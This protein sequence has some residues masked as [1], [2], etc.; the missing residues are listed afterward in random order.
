MRKQTAKV[1]VGSCPTCKFYAG[2]V[3]QSGHQ[4]GHIRFH[5]LLIAWLPT[6]LKREN[7]LK[8]RRLNAMKAGHRYLECCTSQV[9]GAMNTSCTINIDTTGGPIL[10]TRC[11]TQAIVVGF[12][13]GCS[14]GTTLEKDFMLG[15]IKDLNGRGQLAHSIL[16]RMTDT[17]VKC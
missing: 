6:E 7:N 8:N 11:F 17:S 14:Y 3:Q 5:W 16:S 4:V 13:H 9:A 2:I 1:P 10:Y 12:P 15:N